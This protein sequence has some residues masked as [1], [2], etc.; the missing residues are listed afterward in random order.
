MKK[1]LLVALVLGS[2]AILPSAHAYSFDATYN[3]TVNTCTDYMGGYLCDSS[4]LPSNH[5]YD[6]TLKV[7]SLGTDGIGN[8][9]GSLSTVENG[10]TNGSGAFYASQTSASGF[11]FE[12]AVSGYTFN[13]NYSTPPT[14]FS[15]FALAIS[16]SAGTY[17]YSYSHNIYSI[18]HS[19]T[20]QLTQLRD[21]TDY[22]TLPAVPEPETYAMMVA[23]MGLIGFVARRRKNGGA[24]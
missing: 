5:M 3:V 14:G 23:G 2:A 22:G 18:S 15:P 16:L 6:L 8:A 13:F 9:W 4:Y 24:A 12:N 10:F 1:S 11:T 7:T 21:T 19:G 17:S 20:M